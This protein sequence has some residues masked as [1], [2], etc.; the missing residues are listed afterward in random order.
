M[1]GVFSHFQSHFLSIDTSS[2]SEFESK[3]SAGDI[4]KQLLSRHNNIIFFSFAL[5]LF[6]LLPFAKEV[7]DNFLN[8]IGYTFS[9]ER[10]N[11]DIYKTELSSK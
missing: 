6:R 5:C 7:S 11:I 4:C 8:F 10:Y 1:V 9:D 3:R 2:N